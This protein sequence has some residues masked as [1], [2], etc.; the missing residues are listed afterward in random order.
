MIALSSSTVAHACPV[1]PV[2]VAASKHAESTRKA[3]GRRA[4][5]LRSRVCDCRIGASLRNQFVWADRLMKRNDLNIV[6]T[7]MDNVDDGSNGFVTILRMLVQVGG[8]R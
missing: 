2:G 1:D 7:H 8:C 6:R 4:I 3:R 5:A